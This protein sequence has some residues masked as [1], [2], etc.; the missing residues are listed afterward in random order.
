MQE[1]ELAELVSLGFNEADAKVRLRPCRPP[2][3]LRRWATPAAISSL[4]LGMACF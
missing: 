2:Q 3:L 4:A 1:Q